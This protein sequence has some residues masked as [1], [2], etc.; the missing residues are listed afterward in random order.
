MRLP[1]NRFCP[2]FTMLAT[3]RRKELVEFFDAFKW[4]YRC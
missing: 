1:G 4:G 2:M 3:E